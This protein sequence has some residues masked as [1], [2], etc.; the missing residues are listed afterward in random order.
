MKI[1]AFFGLLYVI[2]GLISFEITV[3]KVI[4]AK[5]FYSPYGGVQVNWWRLIM[6]DFILWAFK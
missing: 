3:A 2:F 6:R 4:K 1:I 5:R